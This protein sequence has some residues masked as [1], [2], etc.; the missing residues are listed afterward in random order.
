MVE[1]LRVH[2]GDG[3]LDIAELE[4]RIEAAYAAKTRGELAE[5]SPICPS[6]LRGA[7]GAGCRGL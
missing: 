1:R 7:A 5:P 3:R 6:R 2:A 4:R